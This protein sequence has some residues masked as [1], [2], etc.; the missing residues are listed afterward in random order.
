M[1]IDAAPV[2]AWRFTRLV[3]E[4]DDSERTCNM[5]PKLASKEVDYDP[6]CPHCESKLD[7]VGWRK[8]KSWGTAEYVFICP[9]CKKVLGVGTAMH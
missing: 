4:N 2:S 1:L 3:A 8:I 6:L 7:E 5:A 9:H